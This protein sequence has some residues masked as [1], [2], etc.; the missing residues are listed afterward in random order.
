MNKY[1]KYL[2]ENIINFDVTDYSDDGETVY[3]DIYGQLRENDIKDLILIMEDTLC[4]NSHYNLWQPDN[5]FPKVYPDI[6]NYRCFVCPHSNY[7][8]QTLGPR[9]RKGYPKEYFYTYTITLE[10]GGLN[11]YYNTGRL[12]NPKP[13]CVISEHIYNFISR[14]TININSIIIRHLQ[15][16]DANGCTYVDV[17][18]PKNLWIFKEK[19]TKYT[20]T[21]IANFPNSCYPAPDPSLLNITDP[22]SPNLF[23]LYRYEFTS[24]DLYFTLLEKIINLGFSVIDKEQNIYNGSNIQA[25]IDYQISG[26]AAKDRE[27][28][29][30]SELNFIVNQIGQ[31]NV[32][33]FQDIIDNITLKKNN[34]YIKSINGR[35]N[36]KLCYDQT[37]IG[38]L[39]QNNIITDDNLLRS[40]KE[41]RGA[42]LYKLFYNIGKF[43]MKS[44]KG[45]PFNM[46]TCVNGYEYY[47][48]FYGEVMKQVDIQDLQIYFKTPADLYKLYFTIG[49][50]L[51]QCKGLE[52]INITPN[53]KYAYDEY[54][55]ETY[56]DVEYDEETIK[57]HNSQITDISGFD[58]T[59]LNKQLI[60]IIKYYHKKRK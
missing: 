51:K 30:Q 10:D 48:D 16:F 54:S 8:T 52:T 45:N 14:S 17:N 6:P 36:V 44:Y 60:E 20:P 57:N 22:T 39:E 1:V 43:N 4:V 42:I 5:D 9:K 32:D 50:T 41:I 55:D 33:M 26:Q 2:I 58:F 27:N 15:S 49:V 18:A 19:G 3:D 7:V 23:K 46:F 25:A 13:A 31:T 37:I 29:H 12:N 59:Y 28:K 24:E 35:R 11:I 56:E 53:V 47:S 21:F 40:N 34:M 38:L